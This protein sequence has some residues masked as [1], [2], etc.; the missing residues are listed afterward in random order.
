MPTDYVHMLSLNS[1]GSATQHPVLLDI[2]TFGTGT[3]GHETPFAQLG[4]R[5]LQQEA[6]VSG[7]ALAA[8]RTNHATVIADLLAGGN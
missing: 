5:F 4:K 3:F 6:S 7:T 2:D 8:M 1:D